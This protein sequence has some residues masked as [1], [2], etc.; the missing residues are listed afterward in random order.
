MEN[1]STPKTNVAVLALLVVVIFLFLTATAFILKRA[2]NQ[3]LRPP[4][5]TSAPKTVSKG[6]VMKIKSPAGKRIYLTNE[7]MSLNLVADSGGK[8]VSGYDAVLT[9][10][11][12]ILQFVDIDSNLNTFDV[13]KK[14]EPGRVSIT[15]VKK[16]NDKNLVVFDDQP[17]AMLFFKAKDRGTAELALQFNKGATNDSNLIAGTADVLEF[18]EGLTVYVG[19]TVA[20]NKGNLVS[21]GGKIHLELVDANPAPVDCRDC[22]DSAVFRVKGEGKAMQLKFQVG[23]FGG[24]KEDNQEALGYVFELEEV[25]QDGL[26][27][28]VGRRQ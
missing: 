2:K 14:V 20:L 12:T 23:G 9:F 1:E 5:P 25:R 3:Y 11:E 13:F 28:R 24:L 18:V 6:A 19:E 15:G 8:P 26:V 16:I 27:M 4:P 10:D 22:I 21:L 7:T 17:V